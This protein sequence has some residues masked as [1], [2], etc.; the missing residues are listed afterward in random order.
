MHPA[1]GRVHPA[2]VFAAINASGHLETSTTLSRCLGTN[3]GCGDR[4]RRSPPLIGVPFRPSAPCRPNPV[5]SSGSGPVAVELLGASRSPLPSSQPID[6]SLLRSP[7]DAPDCPYPEAPLHPSLMLVLP[8]MRRS[9]ARLFALILVAVVGL[10]GCAATSDVT[11]FGDRLSGDYPQDTITV[12]QNLKTTISLPDG[13]R[14]KAE[15]Q[16]QA[17][18]LINDY[19]ARYRRDS[20]VSSSTSFT[21]MQTA[22]NAL[23]G[24]YNAYPNLPLAPKLRDRLDRE[25]KLAELA[26]KRGL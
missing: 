3:Q 2:L 18:L 23:A 10:T 12:I 15:A 5:I 11:L 9:F 17:Q 4:L 8:P 19:V 20:S 24:H 25:F 6:R 7:Q 1:S 14:E 21:T 26:I 16:D 13:T 22:L